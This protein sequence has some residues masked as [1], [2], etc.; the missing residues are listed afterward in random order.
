[1]IARWSAAATQ[2]VLA[3]AATHLWPLKVFDKYWV[4]AWGLLLTEN[5]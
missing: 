3:R 4:L 2:T 5:K 1:M